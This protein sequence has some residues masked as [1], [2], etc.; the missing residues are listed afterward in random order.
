MNFATAF[1]SGDKDQAARLLAWIKEL[2]GYDRHRFFLMPAKGQR[3]DF[4]DAPPFEVVPDVYGINSDWANPGPVRDAAGPNSMIRGIAWRFYQSGLGPWMFFEPD[5][6]PLVPEW[7]DLI[8]AEY[9]LAGK[10]FMGSRVP[11]KPGE[12]EDHSTGNMVLPQDAAVLSQNLML[13]RHAVIGGKTVEIAFD[14]AAAVDVLANYYDTP[15]LHHV[16]RGP[17]FVTAADLQRIRPG[18]VLFHTDKSGGLIRLLREQRFGARHG[19]PRDAATD[20]GASAP[21][22]P[23]PIIS[24]TPRTKVFTYFSPVTSVEGLAEQQR[25][26]ELWRSS[27]RKHGWEPVVLTEE[28]AAKHPDY[29]TLRPL[30]EA[31]PT[32]SPKVYEMACWLRWLAVAHAGGGWMSDY[33]VQNCG[34]PVVFEHIRS[35]RPLPYAFGVPCVV[36][37]T[38]EEYTIAATRF[39]HATERFTVNGLEHVSDMHLI[40]AWN[41]RCE[42]ICREYGTDGW[43]EAKLVHFGHYSC[44]PSKRSEAIANALEHPKSA[45]QVIVL[46]PDPVTISVGRSNGNNPA[47]DS[48]ASLIRDGVGILSQLATGASRKKRILGELR[49]AGL[50]AQAKKRK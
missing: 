5:C 30:F 47:P 50:V 48:I 12:Y 40:Q 2:G 14:V 15:L 16:F 41:W 6:I 23:A 7:A 18:A 36:F 44:H 24:E 39:A 42:D 21:R 28:D 13:P 43:R 10:L 35:S 34:F 3:A 22:A 49:K 20:T 31:L 26:I 38:A 19:A 8:E 1:F 4:S 46:P 17:E 29:A 9:A 27:W 32:A 33:D 37:G 45:E 11:G 25:L